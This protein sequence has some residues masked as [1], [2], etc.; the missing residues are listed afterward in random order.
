M[1]KKTLL[2]WFSHCLLLI[3][4]P[5]FSWGEEHVKGR[6]YG[7]WTADHSPYYVDSSIVVDADHSLTIRNGVEVRFTG[8]YDFT[9]CGSLIAQGLEGDSVLICSD[10]KED[11]TGITYLDDSHD[12]WLVYV[13]IRT[14][15]FGVS[16]L[17]STPTTAAYIWNSNIYGQTIA[18][19]G[20]NAKFS[21]HNTTLIADAYSPKAVSLQNSDTRLDTCFISAS[22]T[23]NGVAYGIFIDSSVPEIWYSTIRV[24]AAQ[25]AYGIRSWTSPPAD[26]H[27]NLIQVSS[28]NPSVGGFFLASSPVFRNNTV[29]IESDSSTSQGLLL[30]QNA[31]PY[32]DNCIFSGDGV[33]SMGVS[34]DQNSEPTIKYSDFHNLTPTST[35]VLLGE[36]C[37]LADPLF[38]NP[39]MNDFHLDSLSPAI[40]SGDPFLV[41]DPDSTR[42]DMGCYYY[43]HGDPPAAV[44]PVTENQPVN[45]NLLEAFPNPFNSQSTIRLELIKQ[46]IGTL[47]VYNQQGRL[48]EVLKAGLFPAGESQYTWN[49]ARFSSG[50]YWI[51][52]RT[53]GLV[54]IQQLS[55]VK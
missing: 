17:F 22:D 31:N 2:I 3:A 55:L 39:A 5:L 36:G 41:K 48:V 10:N 11:W 14:P 1:R 9:V 49:A 15:V 54:R 34:A 53:S 47:A 19:R 24:T 46:Q 6:V 18:L 42:S 23:G 32:V 30:V 37:I 43:D 13:A 21:V 44:D 28:Q 33:S 25:R 12:C 38:V 27:H 26:I 20:V 51:A 4:I 50:V 45:Y 16:G 29:V 52:L 8:P 7:E 40:N 35:P